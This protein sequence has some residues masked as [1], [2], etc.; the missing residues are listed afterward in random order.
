MA[1]AFMYP[2]G[3]SRKD[4]REQGQGFPLSHYVPGCEAGGL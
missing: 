3:T 4:L 2:E 1:I